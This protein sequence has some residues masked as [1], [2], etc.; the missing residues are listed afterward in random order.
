MWKLLIGAAVG[1]VAGRSTRD[2][3]ALRPTV[4]AALRTGVRAF[5]KGTEVMAHLRESF[6]DIAAEVRVDLESQAAAERERSREEHEEA[7]P[8]RPANRR[9]RER[10]PHQ[11][12]EDH[13]PARHR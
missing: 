7:A 4:K 1:Y 13:A 9:S 12:V 11:E 5:E 2:A 3:S 8:K 10:K 6:E